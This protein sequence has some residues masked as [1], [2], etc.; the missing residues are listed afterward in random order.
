[1]ILQ[2]ILV[3][4]IHQAVVVVGAREAGIGERSRAGSRGSCD[5]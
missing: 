2:L 4:K 3:I 1:L 5:G